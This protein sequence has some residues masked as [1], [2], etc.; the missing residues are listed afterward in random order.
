ML[1]NLAI[2]GVLV[3]ENIDN[4]SFLRYLQK[5]STSSYGV[6]R[7]KIEY[8]SFDVTTDH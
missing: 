7:F 5:E 2:T 4:R 6:S 8:L 1:I 3:R